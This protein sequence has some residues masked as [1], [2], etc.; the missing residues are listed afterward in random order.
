MIFSL[1][2][3]STSTPYLAIHHGTTPPLRNLWWR[4]SPTWLCQPEK[5]FERRIFGPEHFLNPTT[6]NDF[7]FLNQKNQMVIF[8][9]KNQISRCFFVQLQQIRSSQ[10]PVGVN[11][12]GKYSKSYLG[13]SI[14]QWFWPH[15]PDFPKPIPIP[16]MYGICTYIWLIFMEKLV[17]IPFPWMLWGTK[18]ETPKQK[19]LVIRVLLVSSR[20]ENGWDLVGNLPAM[21]VNRWRRPSIGEAADPETRDASKF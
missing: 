2:C 6:G 17:G 16:S 15:T 13:P 4:I 11:H 5:F 20:A 8:H 1:L 9:V 18:N 10:N 19:L 12:H 14:N 3:L 21:S 7:W